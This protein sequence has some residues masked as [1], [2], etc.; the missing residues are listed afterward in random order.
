MVRLKFAIQLNY[1]ILEQPADFIFNLEAATTRCQ[2]VRSE[3]LFIS[4]PVRTLRSADPQSHN[5]LLRLRAEP[6]PL[7]VSYWAEVDVAHRFDRPETI[8]EMAIADLP[9]DVLPYLYPSRYCESDKL[10]ALANQQFG[11][12]QRGYGRVDAICRWVRDRTRFLP[13]CSD[14]HTSAVDTFHM[15]S[16]VCRDFAHLMIALCRA[17]NIPAR[18]SSGLDYGAD[19]ILGPTDFHAYVEAYLDGRWYMFDPSGTAMPMGFL[20]IGTGRDAADISFATIF[21]RIESKVPLLSIEAVVDPA[22]GLQ[23]PYHCSEALSTDGSFAS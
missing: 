21:G 18:F 23:L 12:L 20:R 19:P 1:E 9:V 6:G 3:S 8:G 11:A 7:A 13:G 2:S 10:Q 16:G 17:L 5:R 22:M 4:Q 14:F 15:Q